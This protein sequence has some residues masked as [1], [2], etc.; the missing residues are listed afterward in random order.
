MRS[1]SA[2]R[3]EPAASLSLEGRKVRAEAGLQRGPPVPGQKQEESVALGKVQEAASL[4]K[5]YFP[6]CPGLKLRWAV[7]RKRQPLTGRLQVPL[8]SRVCA[9]SAVRSDTVHL[10]SQLL[11]PPRDAGI[12]TSSQPRAPSAGFLRVNASEPSLHCHLSSRLNYL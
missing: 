6:S 4:M 5:P 1:W 12:A 8:C 3:T 2:S 7:S 9:G 10:R 11:L